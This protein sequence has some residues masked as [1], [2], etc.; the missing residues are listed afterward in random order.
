MCF[1]FVYSG[2]T[3]P[4]ENILKASKDCDL[5]IHEA[6]VEKTLQKFAETSFHTTLKEAIKIADDC[7]AKQTILTHF[8]N[9]Y[10]KL[11]FLPDVEHNHK[12]AMAFD[13]M[14]VSPRTFSRLPLLRNAL[15]CLYS[16]HLVSLQYKT[17]HYERKSKNPNRNLF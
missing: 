2:D 8:S 10:G 14:K 5:L 11:P 4:C 9:R 13:N 1:R 3:R 6:T 16:N 15:E 7:N 17:T 12:I